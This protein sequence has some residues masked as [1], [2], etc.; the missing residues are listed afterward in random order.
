MESFAVLSSVAPGDGSRSFCNLGQ[1][2]Q[3]LGSGSVRG[4]CHHVGPRPQVICALYPSF[5]SPLLW[6]LWQQIGVFAL[7]HGELKIGTL[8]P[9]NGGGGPGPLSFNHV[10][11]R[12]PTPAPAH[13]DRPP[14]GIRFAAEAIPQEDQRRF[15]RAFNTYLRTQAISHHISHQCG[16]SLNARRQGVTPYIPSLFCSNIGF[17]PWPRPGIKDRFQIHQ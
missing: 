2:V 15:R 13:R 5:Q 4:T 3:Y 6:A 16:G 14:A 10:E 7:F 9:N 11:L 8:D 1:R 12:S 17:S